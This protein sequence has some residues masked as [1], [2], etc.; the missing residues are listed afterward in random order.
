MQLDGQYRHEEPSHEAPSD[1]LA[2]RQRCDEKETPS[3]KLF[4][5]KMLLHRALREECLTECVTLAG[6]TGRITAVHYHGGI[7]VTGQSCSVLCESRIYTLTITRF[8]VLYTSYVVAER[9][10]VAVFVRDAFSTN[11]LYV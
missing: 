10:N 1:D 2:L 7:I 11:F 8:V 9:N 4:V 5:S 3:R 6:H